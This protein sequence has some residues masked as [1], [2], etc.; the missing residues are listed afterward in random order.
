[1]LTANPMTALERRV[2]V[3]LALLYSFRMLGLFMALPILALYAVD[4]FGASPLMIGIALGAYGATQALLQIP[5]GWLSDR[6]GR[7]PVI[8]GGLVLFALGS[9]VAALAESVQMIALGRAL[10]GTGAISGTVMALAA[11]LTAEEQRTKAMAVIGISIGLSFAVALVCGPLVAAWGG[12]SAVFWV[13]A[14]L[15]VLGMVIFALGVPTAATQQHDDIGADRTMFRPVLLDPVLQRLNGSVFFLHFILTSSFLVI[16][17]VIESSMGVPRDSHWQV[18][19]PV[20]LLSLLGMY[21][22]LKL[23]ERHGQPGLALK[24]TVVMTSLSLAGLF[25][26]KGT[27]LLYV[28]LCGFFVAVNYLEAA[29]PS[30]VSKAVFAH[31]K[32]TALG[33]YAT[34]Q[35]MGAFIG[36]TTGGL[37]YGSVG[38]SGLLWLVLGV[39]VLWLLLIWRMEPDLSASSA[40]S[41]V[42]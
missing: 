4:M 19:L 21:P 34:C 35:F 11:D 37:V 3:T 16:P 36:G 18:Y 1:M 33:V 13:T 31:G 9:V 41:S 14:G 27:V 29:L 30:L 28:A 7:K 2:V 25:L 20:L 15:A 12:L 39:A 8:L 5:L 24:I 40:V 6:I 32:G 26:G 10:Q 38:L 17:A 42:S 22:L 23:S